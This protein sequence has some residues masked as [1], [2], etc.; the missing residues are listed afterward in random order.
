MTLYG[1]TPLQPAGKIEQEAAGLMAVGLSPENAWARAQGEH[2]R[3]VQ[4]A[5]DPD[6]K[7]ETDQRAD[8]A[9]SLQTQAWLAGQ[10]GGLLTFAE[11]MAEYQTVQNRLEAR[12]EST[13]QREAQ[14][15]PR[16]S[17]PPAPV[18]LREPPKSRNWVERRV[19]QILG[20]KRPAQRD[21]AA[22]YAAYRLDQGRH[23]SVR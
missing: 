9:S 17:A 8:R 3:D 10:R 14:E 13:R 23:I 4:D 19:R 1:D 18:P 22:E 16:Y 20:P 2:R 21:S 11:R 15:G 5:N 6:R 12:A 7:R